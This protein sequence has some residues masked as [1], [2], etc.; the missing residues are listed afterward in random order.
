[1]IAFKLNNKPLQ[2]PSA[3]H[4]TNFYQYVSV[5]DGVNDTAKRISLFTGVDYETVKKANFTGLELVITALSFL[6]T[7]PEIP[8]TVSQVGKYK[9][10]LDSKGEFNVQMESLAQFED[11]RAI[12]KKLP[13]NDVVALTKSY[14]SIVAI[15]LQ[16]IRD[17]EY[18]PDKAKSMVAEVEQMPALEVVSAGSFFL[19][20]LLNLLN[21]TAATSPNISQIQKRKQRGSV[22]SKKRSGRSPRSSKSGKK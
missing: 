4:E 6:R 16:K 15:Y 12:I 18:D 13:N 3:W 19:I 20:K 10:P 17:G 21:G 14:S 1:M 8:A 9:L 5:M 11:L 2:I 22:N 7:V